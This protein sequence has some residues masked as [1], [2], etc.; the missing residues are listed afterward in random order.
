[1]RTE[2][3][4]ATVAAGEHGSWAADE[5]TAGRLRIPRDTGEVVADRSQFL[6]V[7][8]GGDVGIVASFDRLAN[9]VHR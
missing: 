3:F 7:E 6:D 4:A 9:V 8:S 5:I 1:M 2:G